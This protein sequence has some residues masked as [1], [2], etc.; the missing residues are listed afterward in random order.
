MVGD[1]VHGQNAQLVTLVDRTSRFTLGERVFC[2]IHSAATVTLGNGRQYIGAKVT[3]SH[4]NNPTI[5]LFYIM[6]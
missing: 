3:I 4:D 1:T 5:Q 6:Y 2:K